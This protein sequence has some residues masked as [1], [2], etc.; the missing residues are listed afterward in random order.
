MISKLQSNGWFI[1]QK[2]ANIDEMNLAIAGDILNKTRN[3]IKF[4]E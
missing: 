1:T 2:G 4:K 3:V